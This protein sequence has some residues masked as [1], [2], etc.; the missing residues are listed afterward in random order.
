MAVALSERFDLSAI[1]SHFAEHGFAIAE[2]IASPE[3]VQTLRDI[4]DG[5]VDGSIPCPGT[6]RKLG[7]LT[8]QI[9]MPHTHHPAF[10]ESEAFQ[11]AREVACAVLETDKPVF[12]FSMLIYKPPGHPHTTPWHADL[13]YAGEPFTPAGAIVPNN[14]AVQFWLAL[15]DVDDDMGCMEFIPDVQ[16][17]PM[18]EHFV[19]SGDPTDEG[20]LL[21][22]TDPKTQLDLSKAIKCPLKAGTATLHG[23]TT[24]HYTGPNLS[25]TKGRRA[26]IFTFLNPAKFKP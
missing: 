20:R 14:S 12:A 19:F 17:K 21:A 13:A 9:M 6:D 18:P 8:R 25:E 2:D 3:C 26:F 22:M 23:Y 10:C 1:S 15:N 4:F 16:N 5:M 24:P 7:G 11:N